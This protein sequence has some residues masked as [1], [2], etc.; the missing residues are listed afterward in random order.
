M[1]L[2]LACS[3]FGHKLAVNVRPRALCHNA[4]V[5]ADWL[6]DRERAY[7][8]RKASEQVETKAQLHKAKILEAN[9][10]RLLDE[11]TSVVQRDVTRYSEKFKDDADR[12]VS[13]SAKP[14]GGFKLEK[15]HYPAAAVETSLERS[16]DAIIAIYRM[17]RSNNSEVFEKTVRIALK[18][19][20]NDNVL[21]ER[22]GGHNT[23]DLED[24]SRALI[25]D[26]L[27]A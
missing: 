8:E 20:A 15:S 2:R 4:A 18:V 7:R 12:Q 19:D 17:R 11:L 24:V 9:A 3:L 26:V 21:M 6:S 22:P 10:R 5:M 16:N 1:H 23:S 13:F 25:E 14:S 27:F